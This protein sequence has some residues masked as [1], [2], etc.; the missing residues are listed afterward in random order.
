MAMFLIFSCAGISTSPC[1]AYLD[2]ILYH[3]PKKIARKLVKI[4][5][6][7][8]EFNPLSVLDPWGLLCYYIW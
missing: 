6:K 2:K 3:I 4:Y 1:K 7:I 5:G 8:W